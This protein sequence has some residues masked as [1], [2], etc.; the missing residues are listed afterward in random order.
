MLSEELQARDFRCLA[1]LICL[2]LTAERWISPFHSEKNEVTDL[3]T[4]QN[5]KV[6]RQ[7]D[8]EHRIEVDDWMLECGVRRKLE[9]FSRVHFP[10]ELKGDRRRKAFSMLRSVFTRVAENLR[11]SNQALEHVE[12]VRQHFIKKHPGEP[13]PKLEEKIQAATDAKQSPILNSHEV[14]AVRVEKE[15]EN[16]QP[17]LSEEQRNARE[18]VSLRCMKGRNK[19]RYATRNTFTVFKRKDPEVGCRVEVFWNLDMKFYQGILQR[20]PQDQRK[21]EFK[22]VYDDGDADDAEEFLN[23]RWRRINFLP[24]NPIPSLE[25]TLQAQEAFKDVMDKVNE[26]ERRDKPRDVAV[27]RGPKNIFR[28]D[29][30]SLRAK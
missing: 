10:R 11:S 15:V 21:A 1:D 28:T 8:E 26:E 6:C 13:I 22:I 7:I 2:T 24:G 29:S 23:M 9:S 25:V 3:S 17:R 18:N 19:E 12:N 27:F 14:D 4:N 30:G 20:L 5:V 16:G